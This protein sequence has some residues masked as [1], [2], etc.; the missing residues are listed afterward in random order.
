VALS[1]AERRKDTVQVVVEAGATHAGRIAGIVAGA[2][3]DVTREIG[4]FATEVF[5]MREASERAAADAGEYVDADEE[6]SEEALADPELEPG[7]S[8]AAR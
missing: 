5:E 8:P 7:D 1:K 4:E 6:G 3:R 2:V